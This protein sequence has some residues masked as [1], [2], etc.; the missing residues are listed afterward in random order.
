MA[1]K[2]RI[3]GVCLI[4]GAG[5]ALACTKTA[6]STPEPRP[7]APAVRTDPTTPAGR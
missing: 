2:E 1:N 7:P 6:G 4:V 5:V 3:I